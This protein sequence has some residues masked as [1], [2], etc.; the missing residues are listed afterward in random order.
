MGHARPEHDPFT[1]R[2]VTENIRQVKMGKLKIDPCT[3]QAHT[4]TGVQLG[5]GTI[6]N[7]M[8]SGI[9]ERKDNVFLSYYA[10]LVCWRVKMRVS[11][12]L[13][14]ISTMYIQSFVIIN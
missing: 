7:A 12:F 14:F 10:Y 8:Q 6:F 3:C 13:Y 2:T 4:D 11:Y 5:R 9:L 1:T